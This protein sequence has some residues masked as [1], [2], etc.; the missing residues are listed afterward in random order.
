MAGDTVDASGV[1]ITAEAGLG[2]AGIGVVEIVV[3]VAI[4]GC[5]RVEGSSSVASERLKPMAPR[6]KLA[7]CNF[8]GCTGTI[9]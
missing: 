7:S 4:V 3:G 1:A 9:M 6:G 8:R 5:S 2:P